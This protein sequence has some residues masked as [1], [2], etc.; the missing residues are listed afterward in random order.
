MKA[1]QKSLALLAGLLALLAGALALVSCQNSRAAAESG[2]QAE[3]TIDLSVFSAGA[4]EAIRYE[5][6][7]E[8]IELVLQG[9]Q[10]VLANDPGYHISQTTVQAM[11]DALCGLTAKRSIENV[12]DDSVYG[13]DAPAQT[14]TAAAGGRTVTLR[15]GSENALTGDRYLQLEGDAA[16]YT[17][18]EKIKESFAY[19]KAG[20]F[21][22]FSPV[23]VS[24]G[25][26]AALT[27]TVMLAD[28]PVTV[29]LEAVSQT[30]EGGEASNEKQRVWRLAEKPEAAVRQALVAEM[31]NQLTANVAGQIT[32]PEQAAAYGLETPELVV[33]LTDTT[34]AQHTIRLGSGADGYYLTVD[35][36]ESVY[37]VG[38]AL[39]AAFRCTEA[40]LLQDAAEAGAEG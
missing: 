9:G 15:F 21:E 7:G 39:A 8:T 35:G 13:L 3:G 33:V 27:Y 20:L 16:V 6:E 10:W 2:A 1:K 17:V 18:A 30:E 34:G 25:Q 37:P 28:G 29:E 24:V 26:A 36:D 4:V 19:G 11:A 14:V 5:Y 12:T 40:D 22:P 31:L 32:L 38:A 23:G